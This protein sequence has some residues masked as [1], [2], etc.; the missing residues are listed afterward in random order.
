VKADRDNK[1]HLKNAD[2]LGGFANVGAG[3]TMPVGRRKPNAWCLYDMHGNVYEWCLDWYGPY[4]SGKVKVP[5]GPAEGTK[6]VGRG[7]FFNGS[8]PYSPPGRI[9]RSDC[10][11]GTGPFL[12]SASRYGFSPDVSFYAILGFRAVLG[13]ER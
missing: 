2:Y 13:P 4:P 12:R 9:A 6:R 7:G 3:K 10:F 8:A 11:S 5:A 1:D